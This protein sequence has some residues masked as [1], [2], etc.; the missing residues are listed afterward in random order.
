VLDIGAGTG[1]DAAWFAEMGHRVV[2][3][4]PTDALR[5]GAMKLHPSPRIEWIDDGLPD[6]AL[7]RSRGETFD[8]VMLTAVWMHLDADQ[9]ARAMRNVAATVASPG[10][11]IMTLRHGPVPQG[12]RMFE[13]STEETIALA[14]TQGLHPT[15]NVQRA[16]TQPGN[17]AAGVSWTILALI[18]V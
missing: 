13:V 14:E 2:A 3:V 6:L 10:R 15:L 18:K 11:I 4:E 17:R 16:S 5:L 1:R 9:R 8:L 12:R 7:V